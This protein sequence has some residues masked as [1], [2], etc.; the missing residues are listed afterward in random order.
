MRKK[1]AEIVPSDRKK[2]FP[3]WLIWLGAVLVALLIGVLTFAALSPESGILPYRMQAWINNVAGDPKVMQPQADENGGPWVAKRPQRADPEAQEADATDP[4]AA[5]EPIQA[6]ADNAD[7]AI[8][9]FAASGNDEALRRKA[10]AA[11]AA[12]R[13]IPVHLHDEAAESATIDMRND[14]ATTRQ[15]ALDM[16][17]RTARATHV[18]TGTAADAEAPYLVVRAAAD[19]QSR[20]VGHANDG[21][22]LHLY[23]DTGSGWSRVEV[24]TGGAAGA[25]GYVR[26][27]FIKASGSAAKS[28]REP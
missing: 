27:K 28:P 11:I 15:H 12:I 13:E 7:K 24:L 26:S 2:T 3:T 1:G 9:A 6:A 20:D 23:L 8:A 17:K 18:V 14:M 19:A 10:E 4:G 16:A 5:L 22:S 25:N 21:D